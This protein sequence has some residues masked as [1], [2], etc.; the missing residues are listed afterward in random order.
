MQH[1]FDLFNVTL[2]DATF[3]G[4]VTSFVNAVDWKN[5]PWIQFYS[6]IL[7]TLI[8]ITCFLRNSVEFIVISFL[9]CCVMVWLAQPLNMFLSHHW[10]SFA[11]QN[12]FDSNGLFISVVYGL[13]FI[14]LGVFSLIMMLVHVSRLLVRVKKQQARV[15]HADRKKK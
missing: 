14:L 1:F 4:D 12:Y 8:F 2:T 11:T 7:L 5:E 13:P 10:E 3:V 9:F 15:V 6:A